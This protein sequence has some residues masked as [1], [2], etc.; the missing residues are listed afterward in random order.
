MPELMFFIA[1]WKANNN[2]AKSEV[3]EARG[4][5]YGEGEY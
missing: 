1:R 5:W 4:I 3:K 2:V